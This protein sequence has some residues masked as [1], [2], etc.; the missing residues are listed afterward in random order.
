MENTS[1]IY[2]TQKRHME[3]FTN[4]T[5]ANKKVT[6]YS[7]SEFMGNVTST[8]ATLVEYGRAN[9]A[10]YN[11]TPFVVFTPKRKRK[12]YAKYGKSYTYLLVIEGWNH[13]AP[14]DMFGAPKE[15]ADGEATIRESK[16][17]SFDDGYKTD[18]DAKIKD[19]LKSQTIFIDARETAGTNTINQ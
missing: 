14:D 15:C 5:N 12:K 18:F 8:E 3:T 2:T 19:Y 1:Y 6:I 13:P 17:L 9:Y 16:Y 11:A 4:T 7:T 10:Q